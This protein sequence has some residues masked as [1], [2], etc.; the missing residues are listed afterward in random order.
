MLAVA[1]PAAHPGRAAGGARSAAR[2]APDLGFRLKAVAR[3]PAEAHRPT[4][5]RIRAEAKRLARAVP[6]G[7]RAGPVGGQM[8]A[9]AYPD[10]IGLRRKGEA[11]ATCCRAARAPSC[12]PAHRWPARG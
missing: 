5:E 4:I 9:L 1:G 6:Q 8:A 2:R 3:P 11:R 7:T 12:P 10:R